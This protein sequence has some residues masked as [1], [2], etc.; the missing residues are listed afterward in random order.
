MELWR[1]EEKYIYTTMMILFPQVSMVLLSPVLVLVTAVASVA[2]SPTRSYWRHD[3]NT[4]RLVQVRACS[5][6]LL[7]YLLL[8]I[9][10]L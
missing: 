5:L 9:L 6:L 2:A 1:V 7:F 3:P 10:V 4:Y 8:L